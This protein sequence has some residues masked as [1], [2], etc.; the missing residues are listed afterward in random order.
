[1][2]NNIIDIGIPVDLIKLLDS[3]LLIQASS[4]YGKS[5]TIRKFAETIS[6]RVQQILLDR[7]G[8]F[9]TL[10]ERFDFALISVE[11]GDIPLSVRYAETIAVKLMETRMSAVIDLYELKIDERVLFVKRFCN[12]LINLQK[13]LWHPCLVYIDEAHLFAPEGKA[14]ESTAAVINLCSQGRKRGIGVVL[15]TQRLSK[16]N[17]DA[18]ADCMN[19]MIGATGQDNDRKRAGDELGFNSKSEVLDLRNL[20]KGQFYAFGPAI[21]REPVKFRVGEVVTTHP[22]SDGRMVEIPPTP[23]AIRK[24]VATLADIPQ[25]AEKELETKKQLMNEVARLKHEL[26]SAKTVQIKGGVSLP[27]KNKEHGE[28]IKKYSGEIERLNQKTFVFTN[29]NKEL[30]RLLQANVK[31][32]SI[33]NKTMGA[34]A[35]MM[36]GGCAIALNASVARDPKFIEPGELKR[37]Q[38][39]RPVLKIGEDPDGIPQK[40]SVCSHLDSSGMP[41]G[42]G[43]T[44]IK[45]GITGNTVKDPLDKHEKYF[46]NE[47]WNL[48]KCAR[49]ILKLLATYPDRVFSK[50]QAGVL[51]VYSPTSGGFSNSLGKLTAADLITRDNGKLQ[52]K[53]GVD[54]SDVVTVDE[55]EYSVEKYKEKLPKCEKEI[56]SAVLA[57]PERVFSIQEIADATE[58]GYSAT[59]GGFS[60]ALGKLNTLELIIREK[61]TVRLNPELLKLM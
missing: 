48:D 35:K 2:E 55:Q 51:S 26:R 19:K 11:G 42:E 13:S 41:N 32:F 61:G 34:A 31:D 27:D 12:A 43:H 8:D 5:R 3:R 10:R 16:L 39:Y 60:N 46:A 36:E 4:G 24:I 9:V 25:E 47:F 58:T 44:K 59:S 56:Y 54:V 37:N 40:M 29:E 28:T 30:R 20:E 49:A 53:P 17:K 21:S 38:N 23:K 52:L 50:V 33:L 45:K 6:G 1:M 15:A 57:D 7:E 14:N 22:S 18:S